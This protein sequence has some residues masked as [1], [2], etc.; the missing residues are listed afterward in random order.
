ME[1]SQNTEHHAV[2]LLSEIVRSVRLEGSVF[3]RSHLSAPWGIDLPAAFEPR[4]HIVLEGQAWLHSANMPE[5]QLLEAGTAMLLRDGEAHWIADHPD[6]T[7]VSSAVASEAYEG[8][9]PL[10]QGSRT[11]CH[12]LCGRFNFDREIQ[13]PLLE[14]LPGLSVI[15]NQGHDAG[16]EWLRRTG[17]LMDTELLLQRPGSA[18]MMDR[19]CE[20]FLI[21]ILRHLLDTDAQAA[22][23]IEALDD[24]AISRV[25]QRIHQQPAQSW[26]LDSLADIAGLSRSAF[27]GRFHQLVGIPPKACLTMWRMQK[28]RALL[29]NPY[30]LLSQIAREVGYSS[31]V[32]LIRAFQRHYGKSPNAMRRELSTFP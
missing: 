24:A 4:F 21:Q 2:D 27:A 29:R 7:K 18:V 32:A 26:S 3:F 14:T 28:A 25:L 10:F 20:L 13:H 19:V 1:S 31:D 9:Q 23:F 6:S 12:M 11:D 17:A 16:L 15:K 22:G 30:K 8:G 5:P